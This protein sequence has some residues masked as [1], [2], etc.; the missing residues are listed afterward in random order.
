MLNSS[1][2]ASLSTPS[3]IINSVNPGY[4]KSEL[5]RYATPLRYCLVKLGGVLVARSTDVG[6]WTLFA[7]AVG[8]K[9]T[10]GKYMSNCI[11]AEPA[12]WIETEEGKRVGKKVWKD[13]V[14]VLEG[15][16]PGITQ[17]LQREIV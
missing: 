14:R 17:C 8:G 3:I 13:F 10:N 2:S 11:V 7:G 1:S 15:V 5:Q 4:C 6:S 9:E 16:E 12:A